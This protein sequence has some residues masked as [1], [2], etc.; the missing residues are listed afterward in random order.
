MGKILMAIGFAV[1]LGLPAAAAP[2]IPGDYREWE[3]T[4][5]TPLN[6]PIPGHLDH[7]RI[8]YINS[9]GT[10]VEVVTRDGRVSYAYPKGTVIVKESYEGLEAPKPGDKPIR[11]YAM[12]KDPENPMARGGWVWVLRD[13]AQG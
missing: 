8:P 7:Y 5:K 12:I 11:I 6:Y 2:L 9:M 3:K 13:V 10:R 1:A 4:T